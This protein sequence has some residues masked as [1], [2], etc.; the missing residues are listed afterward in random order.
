[1]IQ[2]DLGGNKQSR[3]NCEGVNRRDFLRVGGVGLFGLSLP[4]VLAASAAAEPTPA[5]PRKEPNVILIWLDG[6][7]S[8]IDMFDP[9]P[10]APVEIRGEF[11]A[12]ETNVKGIRIS[13]QLPRL[14]KQM[15]KYTILR[16]TSPDAS[17]GT[18]NHYMLTGWRFN[19]AITYPAYGSVYARELGFQ[20]GMPP[21][22]IVGGLGQYT[23]GGYMGAVFNPFNV[24]GDP[25]AATFSV[26][27]VTP[28]ATVKPERL[29]R[30][31]SALDT[32]DQFQRNAETA[33]RGVLA[34]D[35]FYARAFDLVTSP[36][37]KKAFDLSEEKAELRD[38]YGR[39]SFGQGCLL[40]RRLVEA[41]TRFVHIQKNGWDT[42]TSNFTSLKG[43]RLPELDQ[44]YAALLADLSQ[45]GLLANTIVICM[46]EFGRTP[47][48]NSSAGRDHW[49][50]AMFVTIGGGP[51][52][53][54]MTV[55]ESD[56]IAE[57]PAE[58][59]IKVE[60]VATTLYDAL[61]VNH[62][63]M[64]QSPDGRPI[65]IADGGSVI[66]EIV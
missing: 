53:C 58:R 60:D 23:T 35:E 22:V 48:V 19:P 14:A 1:V 11:G 15:D 64:Y 40:A 51:I 24:G 54:G 38:Q 43:S 6:G 7:P 41:G 28:P 56:K 26:K 18:G 5:S 4:S 59:P 46:G 29:A 13:D 20:K 63:K 33:Q 55:G 25:N 49:S 3:S 66:P 8:H 30:R 45:R 61:G 21:Y 31:K 42:H 47:K 16:V 32:L 37:A 9:K 27:D 62:D 57:Y 52:K 34:M 44:G 50:Q 65:R 36:A 39:N 2:F 10:D 12:I 17:H